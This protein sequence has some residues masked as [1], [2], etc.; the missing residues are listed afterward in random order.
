[1]GAVLDH[2]IKVGDK[3][4]QTIERRGTDGKLRTQ[5]RVI[6]ITGAPTLSSPVNYMIRR[7]DAHPHR[8]GR[9][10]SMRRADLY[11]KYEVS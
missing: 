2:A 11:R 5:K 7:N 6:E 4:T 3:W 8:K 10:G 1:M 9:T